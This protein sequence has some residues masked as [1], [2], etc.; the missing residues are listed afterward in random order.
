MKLKD[1]VKVVKLIEKEAMNL[2]GGY[3]D[4]TDLLDQTGTI[5]RVISP[6]TK[7]EQYGIE[8]DDYF[9]QMTRERTGIIFTADQLEVVNIKIDGVNT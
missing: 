8:F 1:K 4:L 2:W 7:Y 6:D 3:D 5:T 9:A